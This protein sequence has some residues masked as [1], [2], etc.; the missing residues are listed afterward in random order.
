MCF[1]Y[2]PPTRSGWL[3]Q[4]VPIRLRNVG[5]L[6]HLVERKCG[7]G[8]GNGN[9]CVICRVGLGRCGCRGSGVLR[10]DLGRGGE[11]MEVGLV[12]EM[13]VGLLVLG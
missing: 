13:E 5:S 7:N 6:L 10:M 9:V 4:I 8:N 12:I 2:P 11:K 1:K 3:I